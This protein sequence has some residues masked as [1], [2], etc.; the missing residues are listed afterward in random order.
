[1]PA[2]KGHEGRTSSETRARHEEQAQHPARTGRNGGLSRVVLLRVLR[3]LRRSSISVWCGFTA[4]ANGACYGASSAQ[5]ATA[6]PRAHLAKARRN[7]GRAGPGDGAPGGAPRDSRC[8]LGPGDSISTPGSMVQMV[9]E[10]ALR[11]ISRRRH[12]AAE[13]GEAT[14]TLATTSSRVRRRP[15]RAPARPAQ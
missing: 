2:P 12:T 13:H 4:A 14:M 3:R 9:S 1:M 15:H 11:R 5:T 8:A 10:F 6:T 7:R